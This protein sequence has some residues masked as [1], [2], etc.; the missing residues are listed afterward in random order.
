MPVVYIFEIVSENINK[1]IVT[2]LN[3][4]KIA[5]KVNKD[6]RPIKYAT[7]KIPTDAYNN[8]TQ[9]LYVGSVSNNL[10]SRIK[11]HFG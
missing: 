9:V 10:I 7:V 6:G 11:Q 8:N 2:E 4:F 1:E 5:G 3:N